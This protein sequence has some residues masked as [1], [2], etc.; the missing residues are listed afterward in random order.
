MQ[1][2]GRYKVQ[3]IDR[4]LAILEVLAGEGPALTLAELATR[5]KL[6]KSTMLRL[7]GV[8]Q[9]HRFVHREPRSGDYQLGL[10][11]VELGAIASA[12]LDFVNRARP[13]LHRLMSVTGET[14]FL[15]VLDGG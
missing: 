8:L 14:V 11:L 6:P 4:A 5:M 2:E 12:Q 1:T 10:K 3:V 7:L 9:Q 15:S 13:H